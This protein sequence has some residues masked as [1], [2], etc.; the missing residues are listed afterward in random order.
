MLR[1]SRVH[2]SL[3]QRRRRAASPT[4]PV[5]VSRGTPMLLLLL[6][7]RPPPPSQRAPRD[8]AVIE[9]RAAPLKHRAPSTEPAPSPSPVCGDRPRGREQG[10]ETGSSPPAPPLSPPGTAGS[11]PCPMPA[12]PPRHTRP[13]KAA[14]GSSP[15]LGQSTSGPRIQC[16][17]PIK[18]GCCACAMPSRA[19]ALSAALSVLDVW[20]R[21]L[22]GEGKV[23]STDARRCLSHKKN[24]TNK[25]AL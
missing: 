1:G 11:R 16:A 22:E 24:R 13:A 25:G 17:P 10:G 14:I 21:W 19:H 15:A 9:P 8:P 20:R 4:L 5:P 6:C 18:A 23:R 12:S 3:C 2:Q 7:P